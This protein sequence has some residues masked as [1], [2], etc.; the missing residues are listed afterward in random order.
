MGQRRLIVELIKP[1]HYDD[2][3][4]VIQWMRS[5]IPSNSLACVYALAQDIAAR[6]AL[7]ADVAIEINAYDE[8]HTV[9]PIKRIARRIKRADAGLVC[10]VGVQSNQ[11][12]RAMDIA[13]QFRADG[14]QVAIGGFHV[15][16][17]LAMLP[18]LPPDLVEAQQTGVSLFAGEAEKRLGEVFADALVGALKPL[19]NYM[20]DL[21]GLQQAVTPFLPIDIVRRYGDR[22]GAFD[23]G[24]GCPF[25]CSFCTIINVQGRKSRWRDADDVEQLVRVSLAQG[26]HR[27]FITDDNFA[28]NRNWEAIFDRLIEMRERD[29]IDVHL[30]IQVDTLCYRIPRFISKAAQAGVKRVFIGLENINP[31]NLLQAK[32]KQNRV[33]EYRKLFLEWRAHGVITFAGY[34]LGFPNDTPDRIARDIKTVQEQLP[35]DMLEFFILTP[36]PGSEDHQKL[37]K[38]GVWMDPDMNKYDVEHVATGH[39]LMSKSEWEGA[40][41]S[42]WELYYSPEHIERILRRGKA[43]GIRTSRLVNHVMQFS[44][45]F[46]QEKVHPL[47]GGFLRRKLRRHRRFGLP[48]ESP[49]RFYPRRVWEVLDTNVRLLA[50]FVHLQWLRRRIERDP[51][52]YVDAALIMPDAET[53]N[54]AFSAPAKKA[55]AAAA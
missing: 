19:Y 30:V 22:Q 24:R 20:D 54:S 28:R 43:S 4:Y 13:R 17:C 10:L 45:T 35:V 42:A 2:D 34:I 36:L 1:S 31:D 41:R 29:G 38:A 53:D 52:P 7:G 27:F 14:M 55:A 15:S 21:P 25:Q 33:H 39:A 16:G 5:W 37:H 11:F 12:P 48:R 9:I 18:A 6:Q 44:F 40:Y 46:R 8:C 50:F 32:K 23:A 47:Q 49:L 26:V 3:G 51:T